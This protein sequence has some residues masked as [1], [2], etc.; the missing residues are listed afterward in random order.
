MGFETA[1][2]RFGFVC[3]FLGFVVGLTVMFPLGYWI[4]RRRLKRR[5]NLPQVVWMDGND[6][7][8]R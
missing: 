7:P 2:D 8:G 4:G 5:E 3:L 6:R 1:V